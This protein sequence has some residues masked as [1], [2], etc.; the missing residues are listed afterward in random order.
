MTHQ[1]AVTAQDT[2]QRLIDLARLQGKSS[3]AL[4]F[5][6][7]WLV[8]GKLSAQ[9]R[10]S[11]V[12]HVT[13][14][15]ADEQVMNR[16]QRLDAPP[17]LREALSRALA[18]RGF[19]IQHEA[20][21][22]VTQFLDGP[23]KAQWGLHDAA[24]AP[25][26]RAR[27]SMD[28]VFAYDPTLCD[29]AV[30]SLHVQPGE[31]V[32]VPFDPSGQFTVRLV[33]A[34]ARVWRA[35]PGYGAPDLTA[36][37]LA[38]EDDAEVFERVTFSNTMPDV[39][40]N[41]A[42]VKCLVAPPMGMKVPLTVEW[43]Q[44]EQVSRSGWRL[45][46]K[47]EET[48]RSDA[49]AVAAMW[50]AV[51][52]RGVFL[53]SP[54]LLFGHGQEHRLRKALML[55]QRG[56]MVA[57]SVSLP[58]GV[59]NMTSVAPSMLILDADHRAGSVRVVDLSGSDSPG[60][61]K[62]RLGRDLDSTAAAKLLSPDGVTPQ[63]AADIELREIEGYDFSLMPQR[64][65]RRVE[66]LTGNRRPLG[67][68]LTATVRSPVPTKDQ[69]AWP[70]WEIGIPRLDHW[71]PISSGYDRSMSITPRK[72]D[73]ALLREGD[74]VL[75]IKGTVG[76][77]GIVG[78]I[79]GSYDEAVVHARTAVLLHDR[80]FEDGAPKSPAA[81]AAASCVALRVNRQLVLP[82]YLLLYLRSDD[83]KRQ[84]EALRVGATIAHIT[85]AALLSGVQ[86]LLLPLEQQQRVCEQYREFCELEEQVES[87][88]ERMQGMRDALF[89]TTEQH[90]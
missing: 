31:L 27:F 72:A 85:P 3:D 17:V 1:S 18:D 19:G 43:R 10:I 16:I 87:L 53:T 32:W 90:N 60:G 36:L 62:N 11:V 61:I 22:L 6:L 80:H 54:S 59:L 76:K 52:K 70:V 55:D 9:G 79:P 29:F 28:G 81:V 89:T 38:L 63:L 34:G 45:W 30:E 4:P 14:R 71:R 13:Q 40:G 68:L 69:N 49:W 51:E 20:T 64:Y 50:P 24:W 21:Y 8:V 26:G 88:Q 46:V 41:G 42:V 56:N 67:E 58:T 65:L 75:S 48:D 66:D 23:Q 47:P 7:A 83:F 25:T 15:G 5:A 73:D 37:L 82:E 35:G 74:L 12:T 2:L 77:V 84:L 44:W 39:E 33:R 57:A 86:V 78:A